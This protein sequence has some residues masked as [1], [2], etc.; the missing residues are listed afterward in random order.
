MIN[1]T[2]TCGGTSHPDTTSHIPNKDYF[3]LRIASILRALTISIQFCRETFP[4]KI[5]DL[6]KNSIA[7]VD[8]T[9]QQ[10][11]ITECLI[12]TCPTLHAS[13]RTQQ[14][15]KI[16]SSIDTLKTQFTPFLQQQVDSKSTLFFKLLETL[17]YYKAHNQTLLHNFKEAKITL[18][19]HL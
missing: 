8:K 10:Q 5:E 19:K 15:A 7:I 6:H 17:N 1:P 11:H 13:L 3:D 12:Y 4:Q 16:N 14:I 18:K 2:L 9:I